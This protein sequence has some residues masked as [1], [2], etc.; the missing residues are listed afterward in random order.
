[1]KSLKTDAARFGT[2]SKL[3]VSDF[4]RQDSFSIAYTNS[5]L[6]DCIIGDNT[7]MHALFQLAKVGVGHNSGRFF[8]FPFKS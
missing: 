1:M 8:Q 7:F 2:G 3:V 5:L 4:M 6:P